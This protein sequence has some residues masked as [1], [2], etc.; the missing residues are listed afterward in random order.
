MCPIGR[1]RNANGADISVIFPYF[2]FVYRHSD[3][4]GSCLFGT[5]TRHVNLVV[6]SGP[7]A[8]EN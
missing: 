3:L 2:F 6:P 7:H 8:P 1:A 4:E 5:K